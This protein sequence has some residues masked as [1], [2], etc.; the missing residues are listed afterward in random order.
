MVCLRL[1]AGNGSIAVPPGSAPGS[2]LETFQNRG[3]DLK[4]GTVAKISPGPAPE[5]RGSSSH[6][7]LFILFPKKDLTRRAEWD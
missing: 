6:D 7:Y 3:L 4:I 1:A 5:N 2:K